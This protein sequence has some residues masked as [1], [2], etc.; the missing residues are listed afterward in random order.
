MKAFFEKWIDIITKDRETGKTISP[1]SKELLQ[2]DLENC[3]TT[4]DIKMLREVLR[5]CKND[6]TND[7][8]LTF[9]LNIDYRRRI[10]IHSEIVLPK[11]RYSAAEI[12]SHFKNT[13][14][15]PECDAILLHLEKNKKFYTSQ[16]NGFNAMQSLDVFYRM[17]ENQKAKIWNQY[18]K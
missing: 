3:F 11:N 14:S 10:I 15:Y 7:E 18:K 6:F 5:Y 17:A 16:F 8:L 4:A 9:L 12:N 1:Q 13:L 2:R